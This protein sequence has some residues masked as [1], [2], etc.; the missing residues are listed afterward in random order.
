[1]TICD[2]A[3]RS[4]WAT[5]S[6]RTPRCTR[7]SGKDFPTSDRGGGIVFPGKK[8]QAVSQH[9]LLRKGQP[10]WPVC[11]SAQA[12]PREGPGEGGCDP[13]VISSLC[14]LLPTPHA[15]EVLAPFPSREM[16]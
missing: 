5:W 7:I 9:D 3:D 13:D 12:G 1:M 14:S 16:S 15:R 4:P 10:S 6:P 11:S 8:S 2:S